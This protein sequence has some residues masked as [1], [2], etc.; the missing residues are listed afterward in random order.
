M[1]QKLV[2]KISLFSRMCLLYR[3]INNGVL[4]EKGQMFFPVEIKLNVED[5]LKGSRFHEITKI[6]QLMKTTYTLL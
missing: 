5:L 6:L 4:I 3:S 2:D 1:N